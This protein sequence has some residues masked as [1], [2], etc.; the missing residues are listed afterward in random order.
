MVV[1]ASA[2]NAQTPI[3]VPYERGDDWKTVKAVQYLLRA[4]GYK[5][6]VDGKFGNQTEYAVKQ[7]Q[8]RQ[9][10]AV[11]GTVGEK[12][13]PK[14]VVKTQSGS[15]GDAVRAAQFMLREAGY[16]IALDGKFGASTVAATKKFQKSKHLKTDGIIGVQTWVYLVN[17]N[18][19]LS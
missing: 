7:F 1:L 15:R 17:H 19:G 4:R 2:A 10:L 14:L 12:T 3:W 5:L 18:S 13:W 9:N 6:A 16:Q 8:K 11:D